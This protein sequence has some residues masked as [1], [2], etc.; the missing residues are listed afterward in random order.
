MLQTY[1]SASYDSDDGSSNNFSENFN[2]ENDALLPRSRVEKSSTISTQHED[3]DSSSS[4]QFKMGHAKG[5][6]VCINVVF[7]FKLYEIIFIFYD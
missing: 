2:E 7:L 5:A 4:V 1:R 3:H 6:K